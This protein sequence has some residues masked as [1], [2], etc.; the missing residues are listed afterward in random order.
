MDGIGSGVHKDIQMML[1]RL[2]F[3][4]LIGVLLFVLPSLSLA[5]LVDD[6]TYRSTDRSLRLQFGNARITYRQNSVDH[7][8]SFSDA[9]VLNIR[10]GE[11]YGYSADGDQVRARWGY[12][13]KHDRHHGFVE[14]QFKPDGSE[15]W[16]GAY[17][18]FVRSTSVF[19]VSIRDHL[20]LLG[21]D[22]SVHRDNSDP[23]N[24]TDPNH[25]GFDALGLEGSR[26]ER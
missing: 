19:V 13:R 20:N 4:L 11:W 2:A 26:D 18:A 14:V 10:R 12:F 16:Q 1:R 5:D 23:I 6:A 17:S 22:I 15:L 21:P 7:V 25:P 9:V 24:Y 8:F 3:L